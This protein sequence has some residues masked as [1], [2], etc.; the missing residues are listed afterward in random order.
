M[1]TRLA[2]NNDVML[3]DTSGLPDV[4]CTIC[5]ILILDHTIEVVRMMNRTDTSYEFFHVDCLA[6]VA[7]FFNGFDDAVFE[8]YRSGLMV[9]LGG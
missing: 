5:R 7:S 1:R 8:E 9:S 3:C 2:F 6:N 4:T